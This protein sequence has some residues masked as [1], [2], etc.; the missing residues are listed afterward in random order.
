MKAE[1]SSRRECIEDLSV[2]LSEIYALE[3][4]TESIWSARINKIP[5]EHENIRHCLAE[6][7][8][9]KKNHISDLKKCLRRIAAA[10][11]DVEN[12]S[13]YISDIGL[14]L[15]SDELD[16]D[17]FCNTAFERFEAAIYRKIIES[18]TRGGY[19]DIAESCR[20][21]LNQEEIV[22]QWLEH[23][24]REVPLINGQ[25]GA[26]PE[27]E[28]AGGFLIDARLMQLRH[29]EDAPKK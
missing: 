6:H 28:P 27:A 7:I 22:A 16:A 4:R 8:R 19:D 10:A 15:A 11:P 2:Y 9:L 13:H 25:A 24:L 26:S 18:A 21:I 14:Q 23:A 3:R 12:S 20:A 1:P 17:A 5:P 29:P